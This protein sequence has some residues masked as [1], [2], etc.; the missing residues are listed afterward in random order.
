MFAISGRCLCPIFLYLLLSPAAIA[1]KYTPKQI[2]F[3]GYASASQSELLAATGLTTGSSIGQPEMQAAAQKLSDTGLFSDVRFSFNGAELHYAL[4]PAEDVEPV[5]YQNFPWWQ[6]PALTA[7][8]AAK[9]PLFHGSV[10]PESGL[11]TQVA[12]VL[13][14]LLQQKGLAATV[15][16]LPRSDASGHVTGVEFRIDSPP[17]QIGEVKFQG[18]GPD[19]IDPLAAIAKAANGQ[20]YGGGT[21]SA[22]NAAIKAVY[23]RKGYLDVSLANF[24]YGEPQFLNGKVSV[25]VSATVQEG[26]QYRLSNLKLSGD[27]LV[28]PEEFL[29]SAKIHSGDIANEDLLRQ[30]ISQIGTPYRAKGY[31]RALINADPVF[32]RVQ[33]TVDYSITVEP[34]PIFHMGNLTLLNLDPNKQALVMKYWT[35]RQGDAYDATYAPT[36]LNRN[37][38]TLHE[39]DALSASY[40]QFE[41]EDT[42]IVDLV[43]TFR[44]GG[45]VN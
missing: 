14:M 2:T 26:P 12:A 11:Q 43:I 1:Q 3:S 42:H 19:W 23:H 20:E 34:G 33:H 7:A 27:V 44:P 22:L 24:A 36:F 30:T 45:P 6:S 37:K 39:L 40:K 21:E 31:I 32:D 8:V 18:A 15:S 41:N 38:S 4:K 29:K 13:T 10:V 28:T 25:P 16:A 35:L 17:V 5:L 9:V